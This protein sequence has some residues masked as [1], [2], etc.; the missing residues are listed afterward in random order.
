VVDGVQRDL[1][2]LASMTGQRRPFEAVVHCLCGS[3]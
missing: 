2:W 1:A 3:P